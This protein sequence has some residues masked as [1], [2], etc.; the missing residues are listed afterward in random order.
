MTLSVQNPPNI[1]PKEPSIREL[2]RAI[3]L[4]HVADWAHKNNLKLNRAKSVETVF[5][6][7]RR[8]S[9]Y[10]A[11]PILPDISRV[12]SIKV[13]GVTFTNHLSISEHISDVICRCAQSLY[14]IKV[15]RSHGMNEE[16]LRLVFKTV[17]L[18]KIL[19]ATPAWWG[20]PQLL[21]GN[22]LRHL[23]VAV[24]GLVS[25]GQATQP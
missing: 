7:N 15:L 14:A 17:V 10:A 16:E 20:L 13:L 4:E 11:P 1:L 21:I 22:E 8:K 19:Y 2:S 18:A 3:E 24:C 12:T 9:H 23:S 25:T 5:T 6:D